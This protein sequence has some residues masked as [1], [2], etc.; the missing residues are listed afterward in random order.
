MI[1]E[2][3]IIKNI[4]PEFLFQDLKEKTIK[5]YEIES[6]YPQNL[7]KEFNR[8]HINSAQWLDHLHEALTPIAQSFFGNNQIK[9][10]WYQ[11]GM[12]AKGGKLH[13][14]KDTHACQFSIDYSVWNK[15]QPWAIY[16]EGKEYILQENDALFMYGNDQ[17]HWREEFP[18]PENNVVANAFLFWAE[19]NHWWF[20]KGPEYVN[21]GMRETHER[22]LSEGYIEEEIK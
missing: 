22:H 16:V 3:M 18:D 10:T 4:L 21:Q 12:Y 7:A 19:P 11:M 9:P 13:K 8:F 1:K 5:A 20:T 14:H 6:Q 15:T 2:P 17:E